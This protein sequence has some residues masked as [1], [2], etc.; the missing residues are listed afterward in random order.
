VIENGFYYD[1]ELPDGALFSDDEV[2]AAGSG[3][4]VSIT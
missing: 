4:V 3:K 2:D 1:S